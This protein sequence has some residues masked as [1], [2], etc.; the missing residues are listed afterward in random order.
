M[1]NETFLQS[2]FSFSV[3]NAEERMGFCIFAQIKNNR[4]IKYNE[5]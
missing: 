3:E 1:K 5:K 2:F 4:I